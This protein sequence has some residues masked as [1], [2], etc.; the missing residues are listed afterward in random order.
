MELDTPILVFEIHKPTGSLHRQ[1]V[2][3]AGRDKFP[4]LA[5]MAINQGHMGSSPP[6]GQSLGTLMGRSPHE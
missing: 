2:G 3:K 5:H 6:S 4:E 1:K